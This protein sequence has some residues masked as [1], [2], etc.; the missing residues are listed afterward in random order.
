ML[1]EIKNETPINS[2]IYCRCFP[3]KSQSFTTPQ[4]FFLDYKQARETIAVELKW[5]DIHKTA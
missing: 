3:D 2:M 4:L 1:V 5:L